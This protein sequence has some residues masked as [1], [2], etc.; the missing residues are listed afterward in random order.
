MKWL[1]E[2]QI[3]LKSDILG[4]GK[5]EKIYFKLLALNV[6]AFAYKSWSLIRV[7]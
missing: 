6:V 2:N 4:G 1:A 5:H 3:K 7:I